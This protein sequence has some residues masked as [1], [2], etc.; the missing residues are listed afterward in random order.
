MLQTGIDL[1]WLISQA[2]SCCF[3]I[4]VRNHQVTVATLLIDILPFSGCPS[5]T[6]DACQLTY[7]PPG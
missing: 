6:P 4:Q 2:D 7:A 1:W 3:K 5:L